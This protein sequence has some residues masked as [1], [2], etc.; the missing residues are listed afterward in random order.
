LARYQLSNYK[1]LHALCQALSPSEF[2][3]I[4]NYGT[5]QEGWQILETTYY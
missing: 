2:T 5:A 1:S 3:K 4:S